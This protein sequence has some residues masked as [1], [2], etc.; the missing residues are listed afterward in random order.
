[1]DVFVT[2]GHFRA[3]T[4]YGP[5]AGKTARLLTAEVVLFF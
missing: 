4:A 2:A 1:V 5:F 3:G